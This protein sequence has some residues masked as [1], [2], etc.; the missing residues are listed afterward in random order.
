TPL[1]SE[2]IDFLKEQILIRKFLIASF[3]KLDATSIGLDSLTNVYPY[4]LEVF[5]EKN[6]SVIKNIN[7]PYVAGGL[8][9]ILEVEFARH[10]FS[11]NE[12]I[13]LRDFS[14]IR[15]NPQYYK[16]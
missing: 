10:N 7:H 5:T 16:W 13:T 9:A 15:R 6:Y 11:N 4:L 8:D 14:L 1:S 3:L 12:Q 2:E